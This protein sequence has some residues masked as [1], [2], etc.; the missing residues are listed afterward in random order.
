M[1]KTHKENMAENK[2]SS[3]ATTEK[4]IRTAVQS[5]SDHIREKEGDP[6]AALEWTAAQKALLDN[7]KFCQELH[8]VHKEFWH[9]HT[10]SDEEEKQE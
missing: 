2:N 9:G 4:K 3:F 10:D 8:K 1:A 5:I 7:L 6:K